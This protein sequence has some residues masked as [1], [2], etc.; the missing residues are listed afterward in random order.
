M[1]RPYPA[2]LFAP[3]EATHAEYR[4]SLARRLLPRRPGPGKDP[5]IEV[6]DRVEQ[7]Q[8]VGVVEIMKQFTEIQ[9]DIAG[10]IDTFVVEDAGTVHPGDVV[11]VI[12]EA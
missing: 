3:R 8:A 9:S 5:F 1:L 2:S 6:G 12:T 7:G 4:L 10:I 11:V